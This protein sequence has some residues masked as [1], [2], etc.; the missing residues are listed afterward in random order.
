MNLKQDALAG[1]APVGAGHTA[2]HLPLTRIRPDRGGWIPDVR[3]LW[4]YRELLYYLTWRDVLIRYKQTA[5]GVA[6]AFLQPLTT[7]IIFAAF[8]GRAGGLAADMPNYTLHVFAGIL[9]WTFISNA[10]QLAGNSLITNQN[11]VTKVYFPRLHVPFSCVGASLFDLAVS[12]VLLAGMMAWSGVAP[13]LTMLLAPMVLAVAILLAA[14]TGA[15]LS[16]LVAVQRDFRYVLAFGVQM[17]M[18]ATPTI[19]LDAA[20]FG[21]TAQWL[22][23]LNPA[24]G[25]IQAFQACV[26]DNPFPWYAFGVSA[27]VTVMVFL[28]GVAFFGRVERGMVDV[29]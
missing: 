14:G 29:I 7:T 9:L 3:E 5:L 6:W 26:L 2:D 21:E 25:L 11:L 16:A 24:F 23:P 27:L 20:R 18:F 15:L 28:G 10:T 19:Y 17:W 8:L 22:L 1:A 12:G 4:K 13:G